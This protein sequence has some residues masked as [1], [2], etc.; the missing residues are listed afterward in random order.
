MLPHILMQPM[1]FP[2]EH[3]GGGLTVLDIGISLIP[4]LIH[5][6]NPKAGLFKPFQ[7]LGDVA[8]AHYG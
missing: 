6:V 4:A 2:A 7:A 5:T 8:D 1:P 3:K